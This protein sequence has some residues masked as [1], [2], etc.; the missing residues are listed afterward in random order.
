MRA[1]HVPTLGTPKYNRY[2]GFRA[3]QMHHQPNACVPQ[4]HHSVYGHEEPHKPFHCLEIEGT[5]TYSYHILPK[6]VALPYI[7]TN[8]VPRRPSWRY[9]LSPTKTFVRHVRVAFFASTS[10]ARV[11]RA[12]VTAA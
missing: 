10:T 6:R 5:I 7:S 3:A 9:R 2:R 4:Q 11:R 8:R 1:Y 12:P